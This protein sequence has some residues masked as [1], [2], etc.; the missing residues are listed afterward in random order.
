MLKYGV[1]LDYIKN[2]NMFYKNN[3]FSKEI[4]R[5]EFCC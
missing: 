4:D 2:M 1:K 3:T 5:L